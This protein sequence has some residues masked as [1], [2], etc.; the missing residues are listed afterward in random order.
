MFI[1]FEI[2]SRYGTETNKFSLHTLFCNKN[3]P[4]GYVVEYGRI[5]K[6]VACTARF[7]EFIVDS[8]RIWT[9]YVYC[10]SRSFNLKLF[11]DVKSSLILAS[12]SIQHFRTVSFFSP[13]NFYLN[14]DL[15]SARKTYY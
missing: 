1:H 8:F 13:Q 15:C 12:F 5:P 7:A 3:V 9:S 6:N 2:P 10:W 14:F 4:R 11:E